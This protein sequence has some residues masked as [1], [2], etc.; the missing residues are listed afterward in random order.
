MVGLLPA[1]GSIASGLLGF[2]GQ[3]NTN[4]ANAQQV[5]QQEAFQ[6]RMSSTAVQR[7]VADYTKAGLNPGLAYD[8]S[9]SS[10]SGAA[11]TIGNDV[12]AGISSAQMA[13]QAQ[14]AARA[15]QQAL[16]IARDQNSA[17][18]ILKREQAGA[19]KAANE[20]ATANAQ[21]TRVDT[22]IAQQVQQY[23]LSTQPA[24]LRQLMAQAQL[25][26]LGIPAAKNAATLEQWLGTAKP[27]AE[28]GLSTA[29][30]AAQLLRLILKK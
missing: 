25:T 30:E 23:N 10:P 13:F 14:Q 3:K 28:F 4:N 29:K 19:A 16:E 7:S 17:D 5:Q 18:L 2:F 22:D 27:G 8:R 11:A 21:K 15:Q 1:I 20:A 12:Q 6:E 9:A 24:L 26:E